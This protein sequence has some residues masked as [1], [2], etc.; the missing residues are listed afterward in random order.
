ML[1]ILRSALMMASCI[2]VSVEEKSQMSVVA[3]STL[4]KKTHYVNINES[5]QAQEIS[6]IR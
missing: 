2:R 4:Q 5:S 6:K 3:G 1:I